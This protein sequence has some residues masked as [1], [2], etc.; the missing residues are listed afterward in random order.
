[1]SV[2][3]I[4]QPKCRQSLVMNL[5]PPHGE[6][7]PQ[8]KA[9]SWDDLNP[10]MPIGISP[11]VGDMLEGLNRNCPLPAAPAATVPDTPL[12][13]L[14]AP[15]PISETLA[16]LTIMGEEATDAENY[17]LAAGNTEDE[18]GVKVPL[19]TYPAGILE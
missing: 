14:E 5:I 15:P 18:L 1:M 12:S 10:T 9:L 16:E 11:V 8:R 19:N 13:F 6:E 17:C 3:I 7:E 4:G 2:Q